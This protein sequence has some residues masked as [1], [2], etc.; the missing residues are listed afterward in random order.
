MEEDKYEV[1]GGDEYKEGDDIREES[2]E[3]EEDEKYLLVVFDE[4]VD[5]LFRIEFV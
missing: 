4:Y 5:Y 2:G 1:E 3:E